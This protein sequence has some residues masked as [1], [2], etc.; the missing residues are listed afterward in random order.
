MNERFTLDST[1]TEI[2]ENDR[3]NKKL[4]IFFDLE[5]CGQI[6]W[7]FSKM[8]LKNMM[9]MTKFPGQELVDAANFILERR[10]AGDKTTIPIWRGLPEGEAEAAEKTVLIPF[11]SNHADRP[12]VIICPEWENG[13]QKMMDEGL[14]AAG[15]ISEMGCQAFV[16]NLRA[17]SEADDMGRAVRFVRANHE[18][19]HVLSDQIALMVFGDM[20]IAARKLYFHSKRVK[21]VTHRYDT[22]KCEPEALWIVGQPDED[23]DKAGI[24]FCEKEALFTYEGKCW[25]R[26][27]IEDMTDHHAS[28][29][30]QMEKT[31]EEEPITDKKPPEESSA[32]EGEQRP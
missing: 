10:E 8:K 31:A 7:P 3:V 21:D 5:L 29:R 18:K 2:T 17:D 6:K 16:L 30:A 15:M 9:K 4:P 25:I 19:L 27:R 11:V 13:R 32:D 20:K 24:F 1:V 22:L 23:A 26:E 14:K 12:A 28:D